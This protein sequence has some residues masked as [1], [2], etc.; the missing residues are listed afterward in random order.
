MVRKDGRIS[1]PAL[2]HYCPSFLVL[3]ALYSGRSDL[4]WPLDNP[5]RPVGK[6]IIRPTGDQE[7]ARILALIPPC[8]SLG[9]GSVPLESP[10]ESPQG[11]FPVQVSRAENPIKGGT[12][13]EG[14]SELRDALEKHQF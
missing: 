1:F 12:E 10:L 2:D 6:W 11:T 5:S 13:M 9:T 3:R 4:G 7:T 8:A 14:S